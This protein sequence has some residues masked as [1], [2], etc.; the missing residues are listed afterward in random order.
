VLHETNDMPEQIRRHDPRYRYFSPDV[1]GYW[2]WALD[3]LYLPGRTPARIAESRELFRR[4]LGLT[5]ALA[6]AGVP[7]MTGTDLGTTYLMPGFSLHDELAQ[8]VRAGLKPIEALAA[9]TLNPARYLGRR[10]QGVISRGAVAD[11]VLL[12]ADPLRDIRN[13]TRIDSVF[14]RGDH[15]EIIV[16]SLGPTTGNET[17]WLWTLRCDTPKPTDLKP[18]RGFTVTQSD[19]SV[20][21]IGSDPGVASAPCFAI[22]SEEGTAT[23]K[24]PRQVVAVGQPR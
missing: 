14:V 23:P 7:L 22:S 6:E 13:T 12:D 4:R 24:A 1:I 16:E 21:D 15:I 20:R 5:A 10:D 3:N 9:A 8:L 2:D 17:Y 11:L 19:F 18:I